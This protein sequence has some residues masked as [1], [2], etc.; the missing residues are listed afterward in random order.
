MKSRFSF[1]FLVFA[2]AAM[3]AL[4]AVLH[5]RIGLGRVAGWFAVQ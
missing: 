2:A 4:A 1:M 5:H 3:P